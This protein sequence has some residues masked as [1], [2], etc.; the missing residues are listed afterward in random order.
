M[1]GAFKITEKSLEVFSAQPNDLVR[2]I[3][4]V[5]SMRC[6]FAVVGLLVGLDNEN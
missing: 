5:E 4:V 6:V 1:A 2:A 3:N